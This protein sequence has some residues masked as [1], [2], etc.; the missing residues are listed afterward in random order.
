VA[1]DEVADGSYLGLVATP[2][3]HC[4]RAEWDPYEAERAVVERVGKGSQGPVDLVVGVRDEAFVA[5]A[6]VP[7]ELHRSGNERL[8]DLENRLV[9]PDAVGIVVFPVRL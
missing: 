1:F 6:I 8:E 3:A 7:L 5:A 4:I 9:V 2:L